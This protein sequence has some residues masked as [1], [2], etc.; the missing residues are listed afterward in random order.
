MSTKIGTPEWID[1]QVK[2]SLDNRANQL[3]PNNIRFSPKPANEC[4]KQSG[5]AFE[6]G[7]LAAGLVATIAIAGAVAWGYK[8]FGTKKKEEEKP[9]EVIEEIEIT[10]LNKEETVGECA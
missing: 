10:P 3:N 5:I 4:M 6:Y 2:A 1:N 8:K 7:L 9:V